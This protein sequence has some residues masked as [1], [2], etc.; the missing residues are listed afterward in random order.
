MRQIEG[1]IW[2]RGNP[3][4]QIRVV[5]ILLDQSV[6]IFVYAKL[7]EKSLRL[8]KIMQERNYVLE[9]EEMSLD[10]KET[11]IALAS[12]PRRRV[13]IIT[14]TCLEILKER[15]QKLEVNNRA[16]KE[17][18]ETAAFVSDNIETY[19]QEYMLGYFNAKMNQYQE[20]V[21]ITKKY[22]EEYK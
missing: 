22:I 4:R 18:S 8:K 2:R 12:D 10:P 7:E 3:Y 11:Q 15:R 17:Y 13:D 16:L 14:K 1:R 19:Y 9:L 20:Y 21:N 5:Y 6:E